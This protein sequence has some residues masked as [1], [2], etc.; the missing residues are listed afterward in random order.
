MK[1]HVTADLQDALDKATATE[2]SDL[3]QDL[4]L[5]RVG[6]LIEGTLDY[7]LSDWLGEIAFLKTQ[8]EA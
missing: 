6:G 2:V 5:D 7:E 1:W 4:F 3:A 8:E